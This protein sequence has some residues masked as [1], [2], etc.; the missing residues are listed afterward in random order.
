MVK[1]LSPESGG[2]DKNPY[3]LFVIPFSQTHHRGLYDRNG[4]PGFSIYRYHFA[5]AYRQRPAWFDHAS[6]R[7]EFLSTSGRHEV[8]LILD[9]Q[10]FRIF[11]HQAISRESA[12]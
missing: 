7:D 12:G 4:F 3:D 2:P 8:D 1:S 10:Y 11:R 9:R 5:R 6:G